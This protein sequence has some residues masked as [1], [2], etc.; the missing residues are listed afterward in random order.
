MSGVPTPRDLRE[1]TRPADVPML[2]NLEPVAAAAI[3]EHFGLSVEDIDE[4]AHALTELLEPP[5]PGPALA[6]A[7]RRHERQPSRSEQLVS[8]LLTRAETALA[9]ADGALRA[10]EPW[11]AEHHHAE[12]TALIAM[13]HVRT[14]GQL[15]ASGH[16][17]ATATTDL[18][19][20][21]RQVG[22]R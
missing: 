22:N 15:A 14:L 7:P 20:A 1:G 9:D 18:A 19:A 13:A 11:L 5:A 4:V 3:A 12:A 2:D 17:R 6:P 10:E 21:L 8:E 16:R